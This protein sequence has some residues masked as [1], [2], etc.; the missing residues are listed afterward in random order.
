MV[1]FI[2]STSS[3]ISP[4]PYFF[5]DIERGVMLYNPSSIFDKF[6]LEH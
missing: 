4:F 5:L 2:V 3:E 6:K 1:W